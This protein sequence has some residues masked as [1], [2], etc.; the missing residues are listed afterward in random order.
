MGLGMMR[1]AEWAGFSRNSADGA[2]GTTMALLVFYFSLAIGVSFVCSILEAVLLSL[3]PSFISAAQSSRVRAGRLLERLKS[4]VDRP[5]AA[6]LSLNTM[7]HT[8][9]AAGVGAQAQVVFE[10]VAVSVI[11]AVLTLAILVISEIIPKTLGA[12]HWRI[13]AFPSAYLIEFLT[14]AMW[15]L[16]VLSQVISRLLT[17]KVKGATISRDE[18]SAM[19]DIGQQEGVIDPADARILRSVMKF[20]ALQVTD[21]FTPRPVVKSLD[22]SST[23]RE[24]IDSGMVRNYSRYPVLSDGEAIEGYALRSEI[25]AEAARDNW[26]RTIRE[27]SHKIIIV[28]ELSPLRTVFGVFLRKREPMA[29]VVDEFGSFAGVLT[30]EDVIESLIGHEIMDE[31]DEVEDLRRFAREQLGKSPDAGT[32]QSEAER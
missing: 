21:V 3:S 9:G 26:D 7:A 1:S 20:Q 30:L 13:L 18:I 5:L 25:L 14:V 17:P 22:A 2:T 11:S 4:N 31:G 32:L 27:L 8:F 23:V 15:P 6:I 16:V 24:V 29:A 12:V 10:N 19:T 28:P